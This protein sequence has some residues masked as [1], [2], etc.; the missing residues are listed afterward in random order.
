M[1]NISITKSIV[2]IE[3]LQLGVDVAPNIA[4]ETFSNTKIKISAY[5]KRNLYVSIKD[6]GKFVY[7]EHRSTTAS[8]YI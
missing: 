4:G 3:F 5:E 6:I 2:F 7:G 1:A 8:I